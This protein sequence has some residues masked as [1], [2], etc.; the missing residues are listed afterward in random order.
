MWQIHQFN[1]LEGMS[2]RLVNAVLCIENNDYRI[3]FHS[4]KLLKMPQM[5]VLQVSFNDT[6][7]SNRSKCFMWS[8]KGDSFL[9]NEKYCHNTRS[10]SLLTHS[11]NN[12]LLWLKDIVIL[13][14][15]CF[16]HCSC[17]VLKLYTVLYGYSSTLQRAKVLNG[18][19]NYR[20][21]FCS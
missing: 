9:M 13:T 19:P 15:V 21:V 17:I 10:K 7:T 20:A 18:K 2:I 6:I 14:P 3:T 4:S 8:T 1:T 16:W 11:T 5:D 12:F